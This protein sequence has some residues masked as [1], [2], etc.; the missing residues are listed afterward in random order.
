MKSTTNYFVF[1]TLFI[2]ACTQ[3]QTL[4]N[5]TRV[6]ETHGFCCS[7]DP[8]PAG[9]MVSHV[10]M[11][12]EWMLSYR[13]MHMNMDGMQSGTGVANKPDVLSS[14]TASS[15]FMQMNMHMLMLM[16]GVSDKLTLMGMFHYNSNYM[17]MS[18]KMGNTFHRHGM[19]SS[20]LGDVKLSV[21]YT[22]IKE[23]YAQLLANLGLSIPLGSIRVKGEAGSMMYPGERL[24]YQMQLGSGSFDVLPCVSY[25]VQ[26]NKVVLSAQA[27]ATLRTG[28][29][30]LGYKLGNDVTVNA[31]GAWQW[32]SFLSSSIRLEAYGAEQISGKDDALNPYQEISANPENYG[33][34]RLSC[35]VGSS[36]QFKQGIL[37]KHK[38]AAEFGIP[39]YQYLNG[40]Q[41]PYTNFINLAYNFTF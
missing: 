7:S 40:Y 28:Y 3:A 2:V 24:P 1:V 37:S 6:C 38:L 14:Y 20:G 23:P 30:A 12:N 29:N 41:M 17:K 8:T 4:Q 26:K 22:L 16:Y 18:M 21:L 32:L 10:H 15:E 27:F 34:R 31:W 19:N 33:G 35:F 36:L 9:V 5:D 25:L 11:K 13:F 39:L